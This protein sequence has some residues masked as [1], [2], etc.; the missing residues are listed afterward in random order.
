M[1]HPA[2]AHR[3]RVPAA[4]LRQNYIV[5]PNR[6]PAAD[7]GARSLIIRSC[8][9]LISTAGAIVVIHTAGNFPT[10]DD[11][12]P[13]YALIAFLLFILGICLVIVALVAEQ[14]PRAAR[15]SAAIARA[16]Q[17]YLIGGN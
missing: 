14:F 8:I 16:L 17:D 10:I 12:N 7:D 5:P 3:P 2:I 13:A 1:E 4:A 11:D 9:F 6:R 15:V